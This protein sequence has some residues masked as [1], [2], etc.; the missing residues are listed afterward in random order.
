V[1]FDHFVGG[2]GSEGVW[3]RIVSQ[4][5]PHR[6]YVEAF[7]GTGVIERNKRP[8]DITF[9]IDAD[10]RVIDAHVSSSNTGNGGADRTFVLGDAIS[11]LKRFGQW[12][13][14]ELVYCD[15]PYLMNTRSCQRQYYRHEL[16]TCAHVELLRVIKRLPC[17]VMI[18][19]YWSKLYASELAGWR[20]VTIPTVVRS[21]ERRT[22]CLWCNFPEPTVLHDYRWLGAD[23]RERERIKKKTRRL[24]TKFGALPPLERAALFSAVAQLAPPLPTVRPGATPPRPSPKVSMLP[25]VSPKVSMGS[26]IAK[27][28]GRRRRSDIASPV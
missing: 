22:E 15:P 7:Y 18:S 25:A 26:R 13:G 6:V 28:G 27:N 5:P 12:Q 23:F 1:K 4:M 3:Q 8:A 9:C 24:V 17:Y 2:K 10:P 14:D 20:L 21:G 19:G 11:W 16:P